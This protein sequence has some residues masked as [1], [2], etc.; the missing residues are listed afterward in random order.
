MAFLYVTE[1][2]AVIQKRGQRL[3]VAKDGQTL[4]DIPAVRLEGVLIFGNVQ[5][6][7]QA[8]RLMLEHEIE[9]GLFTSTGKLLGQL[10]SPA[11]GNITLR[12]AQY[13]RAA[14]EPFSVCFARIPVS[15]KIK[16]SLGLIRQFAHN[17]PEQDLLHER[18]QLEQYRRQVDGLTTAGSL[19]GLEGTAARTYFGAYAKMIRGD[20]TFDGR[21]KHPSPDPVNALLSLGYTMTYNELSSLL[22]GIGFDPFLGFFHK[23]RYGHASLASDLCE[24][25]RAP[26]ADRLTLYLINNAIF[27]PDDFQ[28][29]TPSGGAY[30]TNDARKRYFAEYEKF[31]TRPMPDSNGEKP[32]SL[33]RLFL[34]QAERMR[35][36]LMTGDDYRP[37]QFR[38]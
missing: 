30:L 15:A 32:M 4:A 11:P 35:Q 29:H 9:M 18:E 24:E 19:L 17:H 16:N 36:T 38:W 20:F 22:D 23:P 37:F 14:D 34:R 3:V 25:F 13:A 10:T 27:K 31:V 5:F 7:T 6:T 26:L 21:K 8:V 2:G 1:Q 33:R 28:L 12:Q